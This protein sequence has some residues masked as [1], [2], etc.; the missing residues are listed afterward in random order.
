MHQLFLPKPPYTGCPSLGGLGRRK[1]S[2]K[3]HLRYTQKKLA[4]KELTKLKE[5][6]GI[7]RGRVIYA[8]AECGAINA[9]SIYTNARIERVS[10]SI[11]AVAL[12]VNEK[13]ACH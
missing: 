5:E 4:G 6:N 8:F 12:P 13:S 3:I 7:Y 2:R 9:L 10:I 1:L 11:S